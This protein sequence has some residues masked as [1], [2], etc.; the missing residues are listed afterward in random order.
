[1]PG[2][3]G[4]KGRRRRRRE[5]LPDDL[6][7]ESRYWNLKQEAPDFILWSWLWKEAVDNVMNA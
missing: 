1:V 6:T 5:Q 2:N 7:E 4:G 3:V